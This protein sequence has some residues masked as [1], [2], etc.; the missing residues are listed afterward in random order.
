VHFAEFEQLV[1]LENFANEGFWSMQ[2]MRIFGIFWW[3]W[4][5]TRYAGLFYQTRDI[6]TGVAVFCSCVLSTND[7]LN[8]ST[9]HFT[10]APQSQSC[11]HSFSSFV[12][13]GFWQ[14]ALLL[15]FQ[16]V[17]CRWSGKLLTDCL[18]TWMQIIMF[19]DIRSHFMRNLTFTRSNFV[20]Q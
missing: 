4:F 20:L 8:K 17:S 15:P 1:V 5:Q 10:L 2:V 18:C 16:V 12:N 19:F 6:E 13:E 14:S 9:L 7:G 3:K 11:N